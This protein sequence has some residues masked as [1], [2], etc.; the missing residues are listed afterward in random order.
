MH[1]VLNGHAKVGGVVDEHLAKQLSGNPGGVF[2][3]FCGQSA[4]ATAINFARGAE[5]DDVTKISQ[6]QWF[7]D[8]LKA[9]ENQYTANSP[10]WP[11]VARIDWLCDLMRDE[12]SNEF[13]VE[14]L[15]TGDRET[16]KSRM[17]DA[18]DGGAYVVA[19]NQTDGG[20][21]HFL[22]VY[23]IDYQ[24]AKQGGGTVYYGDPLLN[25]LDTVDFATFLDRML[26]QSQHALYNA[27][28]VKL[29]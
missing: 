8:R 25:K 28:S 19:L 12:K 17:F 18:L 29:K 1:G 4:T 7:H 26:A 2:W 16:I 24:P 6:L 14:S 27:F 5:P 21:G 20:E 22:T 11:Y 3:G 23:A 13:S 15:T 10:G 9:R